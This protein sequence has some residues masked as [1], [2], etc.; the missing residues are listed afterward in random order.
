MLTTESA[1]AADTPRERFAAALDRLD[2]RARQG[3]R[4]AI[5]A[6]HAVEDGAAAV[7]LRIRR[8]PLGAVGVSLATGAVLGAAIGLAVVC[9]FVS[10]A[11]AD[12]RADS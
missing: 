10:R 5:R 2:T 12:Q 1:T 6:Q 7:S 11:D 9:A 4:L 8:H 3:R